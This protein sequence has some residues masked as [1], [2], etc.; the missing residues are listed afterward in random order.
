MTQEESS[1]HE[2]ESIFSLITPSV[3]TATPRSRQNPRRLQKNYTVTEAENKQ[4]VLTLISEKLQNQNKYSNYT[5][6]IG[7]ELDALPPMMLTNCPKL[8][9]DSIF[10]AKCGQLTAESRI[11]T[12][13]QT[14]TLLDPGTNSQQRRNYSATTPSNPQHYSNSSNEYN[15]QSPTWQKPSAS[16]YYNSFVS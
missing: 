13:S 8:I 5:A 10:N 14:S 16:S 9:N 11:V 4:T 1:Q 15:N 12:G 7:Q 3:S 2:Q 6:Y